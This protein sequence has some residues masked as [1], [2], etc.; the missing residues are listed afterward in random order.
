MSV[1]YWEREAVMFISD[2]VL[3][4]NNINYNITERRFKKK[5]HREMSSGKKM[6]IKTK[7][8]MINCYL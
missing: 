4:R 8:K 2:Y 5:S 7:Q 1:L 3:Y 6:S